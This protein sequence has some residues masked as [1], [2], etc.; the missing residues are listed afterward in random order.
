MKRYPQKKAEKTKQSKNS[1]KRP[2]AR[3]I[4]KKA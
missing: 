3:K 2:R 4:M 1:V